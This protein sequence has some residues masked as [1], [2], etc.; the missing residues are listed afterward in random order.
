[1]ILHNADFSLVLICSPYEQS[2]SP[3]DDAFDPDSVKFPDDLAWIRE[4]CFLH[5]P[6]VT[7]FTNIIDAYLSWNFIN[8]NFSPSHDISPNC[9][10]RVKDDKAFYCATLFP[11]E[12]KHE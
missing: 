3:A 5:G 2:Q 8:F 12:K 6:C 11:E 10:D 1:M 9:Y 4:S 7:T